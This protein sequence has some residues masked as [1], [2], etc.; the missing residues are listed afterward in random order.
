MAYGVTNLRLLRR[1]NNII[2]SEP[3]NECR[4]PISIIYQGTRATLYLGRTS[5]WWSDIEAREAERVIQIIE[6]AKAQFKSLS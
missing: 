4:I 5:W 1:R 2:A 6:K 3:L